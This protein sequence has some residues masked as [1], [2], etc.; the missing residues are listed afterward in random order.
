MAFNDHPERLSES[1]VPNMSASFVFEALQCLPA[2][3]LERYDLSHQN[4][5][6]VRI[7]IHMYL[8]S[9]AGHPNTRPPPL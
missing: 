1:T 5:T 7:E 9:D 2:D 6:S 3:I 8:D 4:E